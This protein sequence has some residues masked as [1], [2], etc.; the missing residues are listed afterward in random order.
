MNSFRYNLIGVLSFFIAVFLSTFLFAQNK[1][2]K[3]DIEQKVDSV[4][5]L[6]TL[7]EKIG[8]LNQHNGSWDFTGPV[9]EDNEYAEARAQLLKNGGV[10][11]LL[12]VVGAEATYEAQK[13]AVEN[14]RLGIPLIFGFD[15]IHGFKTIFPIPLGEA[16]SWD[17]NAV[18]QSARVAAIEA[19]AAGINWTFAPMVDVGRD[20]RWGRV[21]E[22]S[23]EDPYL[24]SKMAV[25]R[26]QGFQTSDLSQPTSILATA[27][28]FAG[29]AFSESG[30]DYNTVDVGKNT[31]LNI[32]L[33]PF[34]ALAKSGVGTFMNSFN[35][36]NGIPA[37]GDYYLQRTILKEGWGFNG[38]I[39]SD[40]GS[41]RQMINHGYSKDLKQAAYHA[42]T[43]GNDMDME[44]EAYQT[45]LKELVESGE[46]DISIVDEAV[47]RVLRVKF[48]LGLFDD[49]YQ[50]SDTEREEQNIY[51]NEHRA[52][53]R[54]VAKRSIVLLKNDQDQLPLAASTPKIA[55]IGH[56][57][58]DK[59]S[60]LG[61]WRGRGESN[62]A[63]SLLEGIETAVGSNVEVTFSEGY[64]LSVDNGA[65]S[66]GLT[67]PEDDGSGFEEAINNAKD[68]DVVIMVIG[69]KAL[70][71]GEGRSQVDISLKGRQLELFK[72]VSAVND[73]VITVLMAGRPI[74]EP[75][76][77]EEASAL[78]YTWHLGSEAGN[79]IADVIFGK[80]NP[81]GKLPISIPRDVGQ[82]PIYYNF[83]SPGRPAPGPGD[84]GSVF[85]SH[86]ND[87]Q[88]SPQFIF[89]YGLSYTDFEYSNIKVSK[90]SISMNETLELTVDV[91]NTGSVAGEEVV[92]FYI[93]DH[94]ASAMRPIKELK[95]F[96]K[97]MINAGE[98]KK[99]T[100]S[101]NWETLAFYAADEKFKAEPGMFSLMVG[102]NSNDV[103]QVEIEL[104]K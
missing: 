25:A 103:Q 87:I 31:L 93:R 56:L 58:N 32:I 84:D 53:A 22:G 62:S 68:A 42:I 21:M 69:E 97:V 55:V 101:I 95:G 92:Q 65:F 96:E 48:L 8:Q 102:T 13:L 39:I 104:T 60:P 15:V 43:S 91:K 98:T 78:L 35:D 72:K 85:W 11:S 34:E 18:E 83:R 51:T 86:F 19:S 90:K 16:A 26:V 29:Y 6:M 33:P 61:N 38:F 73:N 9:P 75:E 50:Y 80:Y 57:A 88:N 89:G 70:Q 10:G 52:I 74:V 82:I 67:F 12:N 5:A 99:I 100:F 3:P 71:T 36:L 30:R 94:F 1:L 14:S 64:T 40:W 28:H 54:D 44:S 46:V 24:G 4:L 27:K 41:I 81:S 76:L 17:L 49:P 77:Y 59:D 63:V 79:A 66:R 47:R 45:Y 7:D 37:N 20:A 2:M 23:G